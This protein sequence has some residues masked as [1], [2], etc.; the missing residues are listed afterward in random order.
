L[1]T[2][3]TLPDVESKTV[4]DLALAAR[5]VA[6]DREAQ[7]TL[8]HREKGR[9]HATLFRVLGSNLHM[10]D[11]V[12]E[13]FVEVFRSLRGYRGEAR[14][15]T[16]IDRCTARVAYAYIG[17]KK[18]YG[19]TLEVV[20]EPVADVSSGEDRELAREA[21]R[22][23]YRL[24]DRLPAA[25]RIAFVLHAVEGRPIAEVASVVGASTVATK[26]RIFRARREIEKRSAEYPALA[27]LLGSK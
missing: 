23:L 26:V 9:V 15:S 7:K 6:G 17:K 5:C 2:A 27:E 1:E 22:Q 11:L 13:S 10:D 18:R 4:S 3:P 21:I 14:L 24:L 12:Q 25:Q 20:N 16:W 19:R 8:F